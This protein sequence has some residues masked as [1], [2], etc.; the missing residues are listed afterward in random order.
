MTQAA[1][2]AVQRRRA[3]WPMSGRG[4]D[5][6]LARP[7]REPVAARRSISFKRE[8][9]RRKRGACILSA[10]EA[11][12]PALARRSRTWRRSSRRSS[13]RSD[14][15]RVDTNVQ[16]E[17]AEWMRKYLAQ[18]AHYAVIVHEMGHSIGAAPQLRDRRRDAYIY[19]PQYWQ[20]RTKNGTVAQGVHRPRRPTARTCVGPRYFDPV[21]RRRAS[22][23]SS[24][25]S[26]SRS[27]MD[28]AGEITQ[29]L[30]GLGAYDFAAA[31][32]FYGDVG[33]RVPA[34]RGT[35]P[36]PSAAVASPQEDGQLRRPPRLRLRDRQN[37]VGTKCGLDP[38]LAAPEELRDD[39]HRRAASRSIPEQRSSPPT[40]TRP[41]TA[42]GTPLLDGAHRRASTASTALPPAAGRLSCTG[43]RPQ[44]PT[45]GESRPRSTRWLPGGPAKDV[46]KPH[47]RP[48]RRSRR[49]RWAGP[50][51]RS[52]CTATTTARTP[53]SCSTSSSREQEIG[54]IFDN[55]RRGRQTFNVRAR[56]QPHPRPLQRE[57]AR[58]CQGPRPPRQHL[59]RHRPRVGLHRTG[60]DRSRRSGLWTNA[61]ASG[62]AFDHFTRMMARPEPGRVTFKPSRATLVLR[63]RSLYYSSL[64]TGAATELIVPNGVTGFYRQR[65]LRRQAAR[66]R[67]R[68]RTR[69]T[70]TPS[71]R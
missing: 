58:R 24:G 12:S 32:C 33:R 2:A 16:H 38:L 6:R 71:T 60:F 42:S 8:G 14:A 3:A 64:A 23:T 68:P 28:Y 9:A 66:E 44:L 10:D 15:T 56:R 21:D 45:T 55:Y 65:G 22:R 51:Q 47:A 37:T 20:L 54:H 7:R 63:P 27:V 43:M 26:C 36:T 5:R 19:R 4:A 49:D 46:D 25:C 59:Q 53:T 18:R 48:L 30:I 52:P 11:M 17:R 35:R 69:A 13:A 31:R 34:S 61:L 39:P 29:D 70:T 41:S 50:R 67:A 57:D 1:D 62:I 40:G